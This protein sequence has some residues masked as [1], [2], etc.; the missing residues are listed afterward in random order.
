MTKI[1]G[2]YWRIYYTVIEWKFEIRCG[3]QRLFRGYD[4]TVKWNLETHL[5]NLIQEVTTWIAEKG[6]GHPCELTEE[7][8]KEILQ[9]ISFGF[10]SYLEMRSGFYTY[11]DSEY[12]RLN[13]EFKKGMKLFSKYYGNLWD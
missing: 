1:E 3:W 10:G 9:Q 5:A 2:L 12:K 6:S 13:K 7:K 4:D 11:E 8:W